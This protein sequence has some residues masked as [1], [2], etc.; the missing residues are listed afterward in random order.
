MKKVGIII[1]A[2]ALIV[3]VA[4][5]N[6][7][8]FGRTTARLFN[9]S[10]NLG[11]ISGSGNIVTEKRDVSGFTSVEAGGIFKVEITAGRDFAVEVEADD[12][13]LPVIK[14]EVSGGVLK[15][16][17]DRHIRSH[18]PIVIRV[19]APDIDGVEATG[20][21]TVSVANLN[22]REFSIDSSGASKVSAAGETGKLTLDISGASKVDASGLKA[23]DANIDASGA[24]HVEVNAV[25][26]LFIDASGA[27]RVTY[28]G[29]PVNVEKKTSGASSASAR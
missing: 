22:N 15:I 21:S 20:A 24:S 5:A 1:F 23:A 11:G 14:T 19:S 7:F 3:G 16:A 12:N 9:F 26:N 25:E 4:L 8:S 18:G 2:V 29:N 13:L 27:S 17:S 10:V 6:L 28:S